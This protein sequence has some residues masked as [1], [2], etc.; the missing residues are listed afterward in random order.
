MDVN[1]GGKFYIAD[2]KEYARYYMNEDG[3]AVLYLYLASESKW[4]SGESVSRTDEILQ[5][6][7]DILLKHD[8]YVT[9]KDTESDFEIEFSFAVYR[10]ENADEPGEVDINMMFRYAQYDVTYDFETNDVVVEINPNNAV[11]IS[12]ISVEQFA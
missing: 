9:L 4:V 3:E 12:V 6:N 8:E 11:R 2:T 10:S 7:G 5:F 1:D